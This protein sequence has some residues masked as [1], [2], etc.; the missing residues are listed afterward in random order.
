MF[1]MIIFP[2][3][4]FSYFMWAY[5]PKCG[6]SNGYADFLSIFLLNYFVM[7]LSFPFVKL[8]WIF[9]EIGVLLF[10]FGSLQLFCSVCASY[11]Y[12]YL[13]DL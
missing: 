8:Y 4:D 12:C 10:V 13:I 3:D 5:S 2:N 9:P 1:F 11:M 6:L 7:I